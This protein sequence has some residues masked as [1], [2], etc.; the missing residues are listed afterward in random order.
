MVSLVSRELRAMRA[1]WSTL[2]SWTLA[3]RILVPALILWGM[4]AA[5]AAEPW[6][7][8]EALVVVMALLARYAWPSAALLAVVAVVHTPVATL[9]VPL[10]AYG[11]GRRV[12]SLPRG[13]AVFTVA[14]ATLAGRVLLGI[15][16][17]AGD[18]WPSALPF[19]AA[20]V[21]VGL[22]LPGTIG[23]LAGERTRRADALRER[24]AILERANDLGDAQARM[25]ERARIAGEMHDLLGHRL[26]LISLHAGALE[27]RTRDLAPDL[28]QQAALLRATAKTALDELREVLGVL[29]LDSPTPEDGH[30]DDTG[31]RRDVSALVV[32]SR[33]AGTDVDLRWNGADTA[34]LD[35]SVRR[36]LHRIVREALTNVH[37][38]APTATAQVLVDRGDDSISVE[39]RNSLPPSGRPAGPGTRTGLVGLQERVRL[40]G[41]SLRTVIDADTSQFVVAATLPLVAPTGGASPGPTI[42]RRDVVDRQTAPPPGSPETG[43]LIGPPTTGSTTTMRRS[44]KLRL[45]ISL[46]ALVLCCGG[47]LAGLNL[48]EREVQQSSISPVTYEDLKIGEPEDRVRRVLGDVGTTAKDVIS[49]E[50][51]PI[52]TGATCVY[53]FSSAVTDNVRSVY[54]FCFDGG[55][56][57]QKQEF[58]HG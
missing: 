9:A 45:A 8:A 57:V 38:H 47:G 29:R 26:S 56:L 46:A 37:K 3:R 6:R 11:V 54:R 19:V 23:A 16:P 50:E 5:I 25:Q 39:I 20:V 53:T 1:A 10:A 24:N 18:R 42:D 31:T 2:S 36:A 58:R 35:P 27:L 40:V 33:R 4:A 13:A 30:S 17:T 44:I 49:G 14:A 15:G 43:S 51:P 21:G 28:S 34:G 22:V 55:K 12:A 7:A 52:P 41:G 32:A 48:L